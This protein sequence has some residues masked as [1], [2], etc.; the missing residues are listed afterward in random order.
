MLL[1]LTTLAL[2]SA[3]EG[4][5]AMKEGADCTIYKGPEEPDGVSPMVA[6]CHWK[7]VDP[8]GLI[9]KLSDYAAYDDLIFGIVSSDVKRV[10]GDRTLVHQVQTTKG[11]ATREVLIWMKTE[12]SEKGTTVSW[13][14]AAEEPLVVAEGNIRSPRNDGAWEVGPHPEGGSQIRHTIAYA[15]GGN[16]PG[17]VVRWFQVGGMLKVMTEV[18]ATASS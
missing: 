1:L 15:P 7:E 10:D 14:T 17:W 6:I 4:Y 11:I 3:P 8:K 16:V 12:A 9:A 13:T 18:R 5:E 2:A